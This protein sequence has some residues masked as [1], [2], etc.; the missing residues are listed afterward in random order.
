MD[1]GLIKSKETSSWRMMIMTESHYCYSAI[2]STLLFLYAYLTIRFTGTISRI[3]LSNA[4]V[5]IIFVRSFLFSKYLNI[6][7]SYIVMLFMKFR[8]LV[9][10]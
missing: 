4:I 2:S 5:D 3:K 10:T 1:L 6:L 7:K 9:D 8:S